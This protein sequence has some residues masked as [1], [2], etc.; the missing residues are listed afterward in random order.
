MDEVKKPRKQTAQQKLNNF[1]RSDL[2]KQYPLCASRRLILHALASYC[3]YKEE[4]D[5]SLSSLMDYTQFVD[6]YI[7]KNLHDLQA[8]G[9]IKIVHKSGYRNKYKW[10]VPY[11][12]DEEIY[13]KKSVHKSGKTRDKSKTPPLQGRGDPA[14]TR[15][16]LH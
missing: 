16:G 15:E 11:V 1:L 7:R 3:Y 13:R 12:S 4:C 6:S 2:A 10:L 8:L 5:P 9:L 14:S